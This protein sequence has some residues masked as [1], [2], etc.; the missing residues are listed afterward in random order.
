MR[1]ARETV[2]RWYKERKEVLAW[3]EKRKKEATT[4]KYVCTLLGRA[5]SFPS[6]HHA[7]A[8]QRGHI[9]RAAINTPVQVL[10]PPPPHSPSLSLCVSLSSH[11]VEFDRVVLLMLPCVPC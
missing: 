7:T 11:L 9:E 6:V 5:R 2:E 1:E 3:Q 10:P 4:L 8:S